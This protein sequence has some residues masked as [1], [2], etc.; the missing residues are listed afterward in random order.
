M[1]VDSS[2]VSKIRGGAVNY[3]S[4]YFIISSMSNI[5][6]TPSTYHHSSSFSEHDKMRGIGVSTE[7]QMV[8]SNGGGGVSTIGL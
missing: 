6:T 8:T 2:N 1:D 3:L 4:S 7:S 5:T